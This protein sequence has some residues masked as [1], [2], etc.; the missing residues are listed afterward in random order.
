MP[1]LLQTATTDPVSYLLALR[2]YGALG[3]VLGLLLF[4]GAKL[5][6]EL[7][8]VRAES[9]ER[10]KKQQDQIAEVQAKADERRAKELETFAAALRSKDEA[11]TAALRSKDEATVR[12]SEI[13]AAVTRE[14]TA[15]MVELTRRLLDLADKD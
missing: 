10:T 1:P 6:G 2:D 8:K 7:A 9:D 3:L 12:Q 11:M 15:A 5:W 14:N 13:F 4:A